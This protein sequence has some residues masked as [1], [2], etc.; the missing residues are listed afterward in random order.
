MA[1]VLF[2]VLAGVIAL[3]PVPFVTWSPGTTVNL[4]N[5]D[6]N[7]EPITVTGAATYPTSGEVRMTTLSVTAPDASLS[8]PEMVFSYWLDTR[9]VLPRAVVYRDNQSSSE[10]TEE[11][12]VEMTD[13]Q[14]DAVVAA[15]IQAGIQVES[16]PKVT[17]VTPAGPANGQ[18]ETGDL[19][20]AVDQRTTRTVDEV[21]AAIAKHHV[22]ESV[23]FTVQRGDEEIAASV[24]TRATTAQPDKP[25]VGVQFANWGYTYKPEITFNLG[26]GVGG[27]S[28]G[29]MFA[30]AL[31]D[32]L[33]A[34]EIAAGRLIAG[35]GT[36]SADG[37]VGAIG[38][39]QEKIAAAKRDGAT[40]FIL[41]QSN[42][43]DAA[44]VPD[45]LRLVP[46]DSLDSAI[47]ALAVL[48]SDPEST[49]IAGCE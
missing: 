46:V 4:L 49:A 25:V 48:R 24:T 44:V 5:S 12:S 37:T 6:P 35:T 17:A 16:W 8:L 3:V 21:E 30:L 1:A 39:V 11:E 42:C 23:S 34:D 19:I 22:G 32:K 40:I 27:S 7:S 15:L 29:L 2:V 38:G 9:Q 36:I 13:S 28:A 41:P 45:G 20:K 43:A 14:R 18:L 33:T 10:F 47:E 26:P 31:T